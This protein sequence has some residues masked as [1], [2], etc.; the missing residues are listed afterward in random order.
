M[1]VFSYFF[2]S[3]M[4][5]CSDSGSEGCLDVEPVELVEDF[6]MLLVGF[7]D[8]GRIPYLKDEDRA[9]LFK[10]DVIENVTFVEATPKL[11]IEV[12]CSSESSFF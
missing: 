12:Q 7:K 3:S 10:I 2:T 11:A 8:S 6:F 1:S 4:T 9:N 5:F